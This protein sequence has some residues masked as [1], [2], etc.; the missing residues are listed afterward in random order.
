MHAPAFPS[1]VDS[2]SEHDTFSFGIQLAAVLKPGSI[3]LLFGE[4]GSGKTKFVQGVCRG[5]NVDEPVVSPT[6]T[7]VNQYTAK[8]GNERTFPVYHID[9]YRLSSLAELEDIGIAEFLYGNGVCLIEWPES[10]LPV[11]KGE[12]YTVSIE[13]GTT[14]TSRLIH[15]SKETK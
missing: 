15:L 14:D 1:K 11:V 9:C 6:F 8:A 13:A 3:V 7:I 5:L 12:Y 4:L 10:V 2:A